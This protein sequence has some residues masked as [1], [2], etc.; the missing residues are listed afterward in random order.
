MPT[1]NNDWSAVLLTNLTSRAGRNM[2]ITSSQRPT[3]QQRFFRGCRRPVRV[4]LRRRRT[5]R[6]SPPDPQIAAA[7]RAFW[8]FAF[9]PFSNLRQEGQNSFTLEVFPCDATSCCIALR[10]YPGVRRRAGNIFPATFRGRIRIPVVGLSARTN[11]KLAS[12][13]VACRAFVFVGVLVEVPVMLSV[14]HIVRRS[15]G[16]Y[17][18]GSVAS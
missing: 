12:G 4:N 7:T 3:R 11:P 1:T 6:T 10:L 9:A 16:W 13:P 5:V 2:P 17:E 14:V 8:R 15:R 18:R